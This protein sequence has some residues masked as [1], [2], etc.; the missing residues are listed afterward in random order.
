M[1]SSK[2]KDENTIFDP[3]S[4]EKGEVLNKFNDFVKSFSYSYEAIAKDPPA[5]LTG[6]DKTQWIE[7]NMRRIFLGKFGSRNLQRELEEVS[8]ADERLNMSFTEMTAKFRERFQL[9]SNTTLANYKFRKIKQEETES[10]DH[11]VMRV[12]EAA[13]GCSFTCTNRQCNVS[14]TLIRDQIIFATKDEEIRRTALHEQ[15]TLADLIAKG[16]SLE[17]AT[18]GSSKIKTEDTASYDTHELEIKRMKPKKYSRKFE[19]KKFSTS[20]KANANRRRTLDIKCDTCTSR[21]CNGDSKKCAG[22]SVVCWSCQKKGHFQGSRVCKKKMAKKTGKFSRRLEDDFSSNTESSTEEDSGP[23]TIDESSS[24]EKNS[25]TTK[26]SSRRVG[27]RRH[28]ITTARRVSRKTHKTSSPPS[29]SEGEPMSP[30]GILGV[31]K[32]QKQKKYEVEVVVRGK[33]IK[34]YADTGADVSI[35][36]YS[37][38]KKLNLP[39]RKT[40]MRIRPYG[41]RP[42]ACK[43]SYTGTIMH[44][45]AVTNATIYVINKEVETLISGAVSEQ[46]GIITFNRESNVS[47]IYEEEQ[48]DKQKAD[49]VGKFPSIFDGTVGTLRDHEVQLHIDDTIRP[50]C[51]PSRPIPFHLRGKLEEELHEML[52]QGIIEEHTGPSPWVSNIVLSPKDDGKLRVT[53]DMREPNKCIIP[54]NIPIIKPEEIKA[55]LSPYKYF[56]KLDFKSA[57]HQLVLDEDS[58]KLTVFHAGNKLMRYKRLTM[59]CMPASGELSKALRPVFAGTEGVFVIHDDVIVAGE[60]NDIHNQNLH[61]ACKVVENAGMTLNASK[62]IIG[63]RSIPWYGMIISDKGITPDPEKVKA[64]KQA[65]PPETKDEVL[66]FLCMINSHKDFI[67]NLAKKTVHLRQLTKKHKHFSWDKHCQEEFERLRNDLKEETLLQHYD[68]KMSTFIFVDA[69]KT[70]ISAILAQGSNMTEAKPIAY[71]SRATTDVESRYPQLDLEAL[72]V[73]YGLRR[74]RFYLVGGPEIVMVTDHKPLEAIFNNSRSGSI[75]T[76]R[77]KLRHQD[78]KYQV[79]WRKGTDNPADFLSRHATPKNKMPNEEHLEARELEKTVWFL[80]FSPFTEAISMDLIIQKTEED[81]QLNKLRKSIEIGHI[82]ERHKTTLL[83][84]VKVFPEI[85]ISDEGLMMRGDKI[86][87]P[88]KLIE[89]TLKKA[90]QGSHPGMSCMKR[91]VRSHFWFPKMDEHIEQFVNTCK[92]CTI[93]TNKKTHDLIHPQRSNDRLWDNVHIDLFGP[94]PDSK[95]ILVATD[96]TSRFPAAKIVAGTSAQ[97]V[98]S[99]LDGIYTDYGQPSTHRSD[100]GPPFNSEEFAGFSSKRGITHVK[101]F[102]YHP[103]ANQAETFMKPLGKS[104]KIANFK[105][106]DKQKALNQLLSSY[107][108]TPHSATGIAPGEAV[109]RHGYRSNFPNRRTLSENDLQKALKRDQENKQAR[110]DIL[111]RSKYRQT[112]KFEVGDLIYTRNNKRTKF[113]PIFNPAPSTITAVGEGGVICTAENGSIQRRH[114]DDIK[115]AMEIIPTDEITTTETTRMEN[116]PQMEGETLSASDTVTLTPQ[117]PPRRSTRNRCPPKRYNDNEY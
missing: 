88:K 55:Q 34:V 43:G 71:A 19:P 29:D 3:E 79:K 12:K 67:P 52:E 54:T 75:R 15:W 22:R 62:C 33:K 115:P 28:P 90:H 10:F 107:R 42:K 116:R 99:A 89:R 58:R 1:S 114:V 95:H 2:D 87:L 18:Q 64:L 94:M 20:P 36:S 40:R 16:R 48:Y 65:T 100:N 46:L 102:P 51:Q 101:T 66:S 108:A 98:L 38:A 14:D 69:H 35:M 104:M 30:L 56:S 53:V 57:Y 70:G 44:G 24:D 74:F 73:D 13:S 81:Q 7:R 9:S 21:F 80:N 76:E 82:P 109:F 72:S 8:T 61:N 96:S 83:E 31:S 91:R 93:F 85:T 105:G 68:P 60:D 26:R 17:A 84:Y 97:Q 63:K 49:I 106:E 111:N 50:V 103:Q 78:I 86:I 110:S 4:F 27:F 23:S 77:I 6:D 5:E 32:H 39:L 59:G 47:K 112:Q 45:D 92:D 113:Q 25:Q 37:N 41:S 11:F 117:I